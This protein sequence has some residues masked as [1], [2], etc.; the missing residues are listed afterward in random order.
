MDGVRAISLSEGT[1][2]PSRATDLG[3]WNGTIGSAG[4]AGSATGGAHAREPRLPHVC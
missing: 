4:S 1:P 2:L 3:D